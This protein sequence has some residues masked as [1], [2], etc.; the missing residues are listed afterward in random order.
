MQ[1]LKKVQIC[2]AKLQ[3]LLPQGFS[4]TLGIVLGTGLGNLANSLSDSVQIPYSDLPGFPE[5]TVTSHQGAF[6]AGKLSGVPLL[7]QQG[8]C[9]L[10]EG[11]SPDEVCM[12]VRVMGMLGVKGLIITN[13]AGALNPLFQTGSIMCI[14]DHINM[15]GMSPLRGRN[16][17]SWGVRFPDMRQVY[18]PMFRDIVEKIALA[19]GIRIEK[20]VYIGLC[21]PELETPAETRVYR[22]MGADAVGMST[23]MEA[24]AAHHIGL[25]ILGLSCLTNKN[26]PDC[27]EKATIEDIVTAAQKTGRML[28]QLLNAAVPELA[29]TIQA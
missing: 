9:H 23:V 21:G 29:K 19:Q 16:E 24:I 28:E 2:A 3:N 1:N 7:L 11:R 22:A 15:T 5:S 27:M 25:R 8:R 12:G 20:G 4:P 13:A 6:V 10:Y 17:D 18:D 14:S 26:L